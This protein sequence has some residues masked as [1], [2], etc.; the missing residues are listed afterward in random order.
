M[1][2]SFG[3]VSICFDD[4]PIEFIVNT[5]TQNF[6]PGWLFI[7]N[8][9]ADHALDSRRIQVLIYGDVVFAFPDISGGTGI[10]RT[11]EKKGNGALSSIKSGACQKNDEKF[12]YATHSDP[13]ELF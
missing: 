3:D 5:Q 2:G 8:E 9:L 1:P 12:R 6:V 13:P 4:V 10:T 7:S 11:Q